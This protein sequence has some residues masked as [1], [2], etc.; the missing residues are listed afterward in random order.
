LVGRSV[1]WSVGQPVGQPVS[2]V[3]PALSHPPPPSFASRR[4]DAV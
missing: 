3:H 4:V 1:G 2:L